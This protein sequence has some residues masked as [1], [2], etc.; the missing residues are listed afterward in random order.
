MVE[1]LL[2]TQIAEARSAAIQVDKVVCV[3]GFCDNPAMRVHLK[4]V[5]DSVNSN[6][7]GSNID[8]M[9]APAN[10]SATSVAIGA[11]MRSLDKA[12]GPTRLPRLSIGIKC[13]IEQGDPDRP[14][15]D[16]DWK[17]SEYDGKKYK[18]DV[19]EWKIKAVS[20]SIPR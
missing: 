10:T 5:V 11:V 2:Q 4:N 8:V 12:N 1:H 15:D 19:I 9:C 3:G 18:F 7:P 14:T 6:N 13:H 17:T 20:Q 16:A